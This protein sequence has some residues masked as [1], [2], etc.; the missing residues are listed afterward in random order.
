MRTDVIDGFRV[1]A[2]NI[3]DAKRKVRPELTAAELREIYDAVLPR[4][5][6]TKLYRI[7]DENDGISF[8]EL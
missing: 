8:E 4:R 5:E 1:T 6:G 2:L 7:R 3:R